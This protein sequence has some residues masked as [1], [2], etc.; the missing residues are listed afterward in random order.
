[1]DVPPAF[2]HIKDWANM[3]TLPI[4]STSVKVELPPSCQE[5]ENEWRK[6]ESSAHMHIN[7]RAAL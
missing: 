3:Q 4:M 1:M 7:N 2:P 5:C 6:R